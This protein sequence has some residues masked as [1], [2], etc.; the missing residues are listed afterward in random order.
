MV[1]TL[2]EVAERA[3]VSRSAVSRTF[4]DGAS[5]SAKMRRKVEKA[6]ADLGYQP[7]FLARSL[8]TR[9]TKLIGL[10]A[11]NFTN[12]FFLHA[13]DRFTSELQKRGLRP[14]LVNVSDQDD[15]DRAAQ[16]LR[17]YSVDGVIVASATVD[18]QLIE[19]FKKVRLPVVYSFTR[20]SDH[21]E[22]NVVGVDDVA[23]G[24]KAANILIDRGYHHIG[25][26]GGP[27][28]ATSSLDR[29]NGFAQAMA[30]NPELTFDAEFADDY[31]YAAGRAIMMKMLDAGRAEAYFCAAD[32]IAIGAMSALESHGLRVPEDVG[33]L[34]IDDIEMAAWDT[35]NLTT[36]QQPIDKIVSSSVDLISA[37][38]QSESEFYP[39]NR[40]FSTRLI[41]RGT[42]RS[43]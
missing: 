30:Q 7:N 4:T 38:L 1:V 17:Q 24:E 21:L 33:I 16:M 28:R 27:R 32:M 15:P 6:A 2:K 43:A 42:L 25:F 36:L 5:V 9:R 13:F 18:P 29:Y 34:G 19:S 37:I 11:D 12:T 26:V 31:S 40:I 8:T 14:L 3:G 10:V 41:E 20:F 35:I 22:E 23:A 39:E